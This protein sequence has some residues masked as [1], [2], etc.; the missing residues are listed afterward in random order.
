MIVI[1]QT[2]DM[3]D[4]WGYWTS[5]SSSG[6]Q[7]GITIGALALMGLLFFFWA[8]FWRQPKRRRKHSYHHG[9][10]ENTG[11]PRREKH[12][13][14]LFHRRRRHR[15]HS[16]ERPANPTLSQVGGLPPPRRGPP[17]GP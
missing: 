3:N 15:R 9:S 4:I 7:I 14:G 8:A 17:R 2:V 5:P 11:L 12:H 1:A 10:D 6:R 13:S 16:R